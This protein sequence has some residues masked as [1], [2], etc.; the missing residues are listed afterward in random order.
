MNKVDRIA[1]AM[2]ASSVSPQAQRTQTQYRLSLVDSWNIQPGQSV[3]E[4]GCGQGDMTAVLAD[5]VGEHGSVLGVDTATADYGTPVTLGESAAFLARS[6]LAPQV[7]MRFEFDVLARSFPGR[8]FDHVVLSH[9]SWY[10]TSFDQVRATL[11][12]IRPWAGQLCFAEWDLRPVIPGQLPHLLAVLIQG[13]IEAAGS[14]GDGNIRTPYSQEAG[15]R[16]IAETGWET[17]TDR[18]A[19][20]TA[21]Q[22]ADWEVEACLRILSSPSRMAALPGPVA[23]LI[24]SQA[25]VLRAIARQ[26]GNT[27]L[28]SYSVTARPFALGPAPCPP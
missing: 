12:R 24:S 15:L 8:T 2:A 19:D 25:D 18:T 20:T 1:A 4:I 11:R 26:R 5:A 21:M 27:A 17:V 7:E 6:S 9:C 10:F 16:L 3:L 14:R 13:H 28:P 23:A 22:D